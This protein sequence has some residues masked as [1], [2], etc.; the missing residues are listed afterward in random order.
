M[1]A[2]KLRT[3]PNTPANRIIEI[4]TLLPLDLIRLNNLPLVG[5]L[6]SDELTLGLHHSR[7]SG[8]GVEFAQY[9]AYQPGD[10]PRLIDWKRYA[11][12]GKHLIRESE[13]ESSRQVR[14][15]LDLSGSMNYAEAS[16]KGNVR[17]LDYA[18]VLLAALAYIANRQGDALSLYGVR[19]GQIE[20]LVPPGKQAFQ[21]VLGTLAGVEAA[22]GWPGNVPA[23]PELQRKQSE[24]LVLV[25]DLL[26]LNDEWLALL[27]QA[28]TPRREILL[29]QV[30]GH[31]EVDFNLSG[32]YQF[33][34]LETG[35]TLEAQADTVRAQVRSTATAY[36]RHLDEQLHIPNLRR[37]RAFLTDPPALVLR[38]LLG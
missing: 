7:R 10:D 21:K 27:R 15:L 9:R 22:G 2:L 11:Q 33:Q 16:A 30:L 4:A 26:Q 29:V 36:F 25:S 5:K 35:Q 8:G 34:D 14:L 12:T 32:F 31:Q 37:V 28:A 6:L 17:R 13:T 24:I 18:K 3:Q 38:A 1:F 19:N 20:A 23:F